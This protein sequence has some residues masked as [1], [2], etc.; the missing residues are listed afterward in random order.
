[1]RHV[2]FFRWVLTLGMVLIGCSAAVFMAVPDM[3]ELRQVDLTVLHE[4]PDGACTVRWRNPFDEEQHEDPYQCDPDR[5]PSRK[6]PYYD[7]ESAPG[8]DTGFVVTEGEAKGELYALGQDDEAVTEQLELS[9][10]LVILGLFLTVSGLVGGN[11]RALIRM[12][13][14][15]RDLIRRAGRLSHAAGLVAEDYARAVTAVRE[16]WTPLHQEQLDRELSRVPAS[17]LRHDDKRR[18][19]TKEWERAGIRSV[20]DVLDTG[21]WTLGQLPGVGRRTAERAVAA[22]QRTAVE[23]SKDVLVRIA[24]DRPTPRTTALITALHVLLEAGPGARRAAESA[25]CLS[26]RLALLLPDASAASG[27]AQMLRTGPEQR[28]RT[29]AAVDE[30]RRLL[31]QAEQTT[32]DRQFGQASADL[33]RAPDGDRTGLSAWV[34]FESR[35]GDYYRL[36]AEVT[37]GVAPRIDERLSP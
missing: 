30:L 32:A 13:G 11:I 21:V 28:R 36:L 3:P 12:R 7:P 31:D 25:Q 17:R 10:T 35:S 19:S 14:V 22:A 24:P 6:G 34:D 1:M 16:A 5:E 4:A 18:F 23:T 26:T 15:E 20:R 37:G 2:P 27:H 29:R 33:L 9:D 8:Q